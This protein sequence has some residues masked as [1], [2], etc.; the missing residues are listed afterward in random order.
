MAE[1]CSKAGHFLP[2]VFLLSRGYIQLETSEK[3]GNEDFK[4]LVYPLTLV[5]KVIACWQNRRG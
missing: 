3:I 1:I 4:S 5:R 2:R